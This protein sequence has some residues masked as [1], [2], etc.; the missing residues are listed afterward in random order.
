M[1]QE[2]FNQENQQIGQ[3]LAAFLKNKKSESPVATDA[4]LDEDSISAFVDGTLSNREAEPIMRHLVGCSPCRK[5]TAQLARLAEELHEHPEAVLSA[6]P[7]TSRFQQFM[8]S[9]GLSSFGFGDEAVFAHNDSAE[10]D[11]KEDSEN[12]DSEG[13][14]SE[15]SSKE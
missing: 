6:A 4:H 9:L 5:I 13:G 7:Q 3:L 15:S 12:R 10:E 2:Q 8:Q 14:S 1:K 11:K